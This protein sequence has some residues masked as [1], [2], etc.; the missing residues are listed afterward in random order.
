[1]CQCI[2]SILKK[3]ISFQ[4]CKMFQHRKKNEPNCYKTGC[5]HWLLCFESYNKV[6]GPMD[7]DNRHTIHCIKVRQRSYPKGEGVVLRFEG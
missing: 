6:D 3:H 7:A 1:M 5:N 4:G 2:D